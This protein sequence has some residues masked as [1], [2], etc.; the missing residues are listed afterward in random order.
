MSI[1]ILVNKQMKEFVLYSEYRDSTGESNDGMR[2]GYSYTVHVTHTFSFENEKKE[3]EG[4]SYDLRVVKNTDDYVRNYD[5]TET[6][7]EFEENFDYIATVLR[8][9]GVFM[10][11]IPA[12]MSVRCEFR[13][14]I[15][16][17]S[18]NEGLVATEP[19]ENAV[20]LSFNGRFYPVKEDT[21][22]IITASDLIA[23]VSEDDEEKKWMMIA[24]ALGDKSLLNKTYCV[25]L[26]SIPDELY[27][28]TKL[29]RLKEVT[30]N[31][32]IEAGIA[33]DADI[34]QA[35]TDFA[36][37]VE[38]ADSY[39]PIS[40][41]GIERFII[42]LPGELRKDILRHCYQTSGNLQIFRDYCPEYISW[43]SVK[44]EDYVDSDLDLMIQR[45]EYAYERQQWDFIERCMEEPELEK[46]VV[47]NA[48]A[49]GR[50]DLSKIA[51]NLHKCTTTDLL[52]SI[53]KYDKENPGCVKLS[54]I[55]CVFRLEYTG[56]ERKDYNGCLAMADGCNSTEMIAFVLRIG[57][58][59]GVSER[60]LVEMLLDKETSVRIALYSWSLKEIYEKF[61]FAPGLAWVKAEEDRREA[62]K[63]RIAKERA[64]SNEKVVTFVKDSGKLAVRVS[65]DHYYSS[66]DGC[67][68]CRPDGERVGNLQ[69]N[70]DRILV[71]EGNRYCCLVNVERVKK[72][73]NGVFHFDVL[74]GDAGYVIGPKG[75]H[76]KEVTEQLNELGCQLKAIKIHAHDKQEQAV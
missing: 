48:Y 40:T 58:L 27:G 53:M 54:D 33:D 23:R 49:I 9:R 21:D 75:R 47:E 64:D 51:N 39:Y 8:N 41:E 16:R 68:V 60:E 13:E 57:L 5:M 14:F 62:E 28:S 35:L 65:L 10:L 45:K 4:Y 30:A 67:N 6:A 38:E 2:S 11:N 32:L 44:L 66:A 36:A 74:E 37:R 25:T 46:K 1:R 50:C 17:W 70:E 18:I 42:E 19:D 72:L 20:E 52:R 29:I 3:N 15:H 76:I 7:K 59:V 12:Y 34:E 73:R 69:P 31:G 26:D 56:L 24:R 55:S 22:D 71:V 43:R 61:N 63:Q